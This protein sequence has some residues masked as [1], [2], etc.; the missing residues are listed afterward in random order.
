MPV[1]VALTQCDLVDELD[2][3]CYEAA[4]QLGRRAIPVLPTDVR[5]PDQVMLLLDV[6]MAEIETMELCDVGT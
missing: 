1:V 2:V 6:L 3:A 5:D 4:A